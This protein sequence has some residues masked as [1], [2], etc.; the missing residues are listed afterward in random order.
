MHA[1]SQLQQSEVP[2]WPL[3]R[4]AATAAPLRLSAPLSSPPMPRDMT[5]VGRWEPSPNDWNEITAESIGKEERG[6]IKFWKKGGAPGLDQAPPRPTHPPTREELLEFAQSVGAADGPTGGDWRRLLADPQAAAA[7]KTV[8]RRVDELLENGRRAVQQR[9]LI[10][11]SGTRALNSLRYQQ[12]PFNTSKLNTIESTA[13]SRGW[14]PRSRAW[15]GHTSTDVVPVRELSTRSHRCRCRRRC[16]R[17]CSSPPRC[18][19][20]CRCSSCP[21]LRLC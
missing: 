13:L 19:S 12:E 15:T 20:R 18:S 3:G 11:D 9:P 17:R 1:K 21:L 7:M 4:S 2:A 16:R 6:A 5:G 10:P 14:D 8:R